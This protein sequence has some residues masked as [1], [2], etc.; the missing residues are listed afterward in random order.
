MI[1][2]KVLINPVFIYKRSN[3][4][5]KLYDNDGIVITKEKIVFKDKSSDLSNISS[6]YV[7]EG[8][9]SML[10]HIPVFIGTLLVA[11]IVFIIGV[12]HGYILGVASKNLMIL[13]F[14][15]PILIFSAVYNIKYPVYTLYIDLKKEACRE[16]VLTAQDKSKVDMI[17]DILKDETGMS[18]Y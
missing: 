1:L 15:S 14:L 12:N 10:T 3:Y 5:E 17:K 8:H 4:M 9:K 6:T 7:N 2:L 18:E 16:E 11:A 13:T